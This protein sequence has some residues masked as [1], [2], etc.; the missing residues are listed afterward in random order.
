MLQGEPEEFQFRKVCQDLS[1]GCPQGM[2]SK[3]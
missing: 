2:E 1:V 3:V